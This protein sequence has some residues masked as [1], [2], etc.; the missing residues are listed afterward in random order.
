MT[1]RKGN[2]QKET[3]REWGLVVYGGQDK[4]VLTA[5]CWD[6]LGQDPSVAC[7]GLLPVMMMWGAVNPATSRRCSFRG[8]FQFA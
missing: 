4:G 2:S 3:L 8:M 6:F 7:R 1:L 5:F